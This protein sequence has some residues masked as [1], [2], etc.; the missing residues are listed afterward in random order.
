MVSTVTA[1]TF[2]IVV[3]ATTLKIQKVFL[4]RIIFKG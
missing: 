1:S 3:H 2:F 4:E